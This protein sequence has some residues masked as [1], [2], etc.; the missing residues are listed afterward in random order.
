[1]V[2]RLGRGVADRRH[3]AAHTGEGITDSEPSRRVCAAWLILPCSS[4]KTTKLRQLGQGLTVDRILTSSLA[5]VEERRQNVESKL[6]SLFTLTS[7]L[8]AVVIAG[9]AAF[10]MLGAVKEA[11]R[12]FVWGAMLLVFYVVLHLLCLLWATASGLKRKSY[13]QLS[14]A[15]IVPQDGETPNA[16]QVRLLNLQANSLRW[17]EWVTN[18]KVSEMAV[19]H[20]ALKNVLTAISILIVLAGLN[21]LRVIVNSLSLCAGAAD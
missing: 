4:D 19:A 5:Q 10:S 6:M 17:N 1:M 3:R 12:I 8:S 2:H 15:D 14:P 20:I 16:Y 18:Q 7:V 9:L 13:K 21:S 11:S